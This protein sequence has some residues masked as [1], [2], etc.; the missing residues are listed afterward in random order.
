MT[1]YDETKTQLQHGYFFSPGFYLGYWRSQIL[2]NFSAEEVAFSNKLR[3]HREAWI[4]AHLAAL[5][6]ELSGKKFMVGIPE[7]DPPDVLVGNLHDVT[8]LTGRAGQNFNWFP[9]ENTRCNI[10]AGETLDTQILKKTQ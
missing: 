10:S 1:K 9:V 6:T 8:T 3:V 7:T 4:G 2:P 5:K